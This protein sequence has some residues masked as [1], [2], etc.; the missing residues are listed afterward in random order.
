MAIITQWKSYGSTWNRN[1]REEWDTIA[2]WHEEA[3]QQCFTQQAAM[4]DDEESIS[5]NA[6][7]TAFTNEEFKKLRA[8]G[9]IIAKG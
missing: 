9:E 2:L 4:V 3:T 1:A 5:E 7:S 8:G 6:L